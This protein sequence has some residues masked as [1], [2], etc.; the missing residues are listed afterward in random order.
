MRGSGNNPTHVPSKGDPISASHQEECEIRE[1]DSISAATTSHQEECRC[2]RRTKPPP[3]PTSVPF[4]ATEANRE[5]LQQYLLDYYR[6]STFNVC[7]HQ[8]LPMI[9]GPPM[10]LLIDT[11][12]TP[13]AHHSPIPVPLHWQDEVKADLDRDVRLYRRPRTGTHGRTSHM[14]PPHGNLR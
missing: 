1:R 2:P 14:V 11:Q 10:R 5:S 7:E 8:T 13:T 3:R 4:S 6:F 9:D 12:A